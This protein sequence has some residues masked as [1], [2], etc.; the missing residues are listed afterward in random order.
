MRLG[1]AIKIRMC[2]SIP[3][4]VG[5]TAEIIELQMQQYERYRAYPIWAKMTSGQR[6]GKI[7][8]FREAEVELLP[9]RETMRP[10]IRI[11]DTI[12]IKHCHEIPEVLGESAVVVE[13]QI[14]EFEKYR[15]YPIWA[16]ILSGPRKGK[17][18]GFRE[19]EVEVLRR[20]EAQPVTEE[21]RER[22]IKTKV[23]EQVEG[24]LKGV[25]TVEEIEGIERL[26]R[27]A[28]GKATV[29]P[30]MGFWEGKTPCWEMLRC[31][32]AIKNECPAFKYRSVPCWEIEGTYSKLYD[33]GQK[34]DGTS[35]CRYCR[36]YKKW[37]QDAPIAIKLFGKG[38]N[39]T[40]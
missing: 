18:Y 38:F 24:I 8:G 3:E 10:T 23:L 5:E 19:S 28:K 20:V 15:V 30:A 17:I 25:T 2:E 37:G 1:D 6:K 27:E 33:Y 35:I 40:E 12:T 36:V 31:P 14:Q 34:G 21:R 22:I 16:K 26:I 39:P 32:E 7:Y 4:V 29:E 13:L 11:G 9:V